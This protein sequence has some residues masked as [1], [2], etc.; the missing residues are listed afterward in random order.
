MVGDGANH[1]RRGK[2]TPRTKRAF[3]GSGF[4][5]GLRHHRYERSCAFCLSGMESLTLPLNYLDGGGGDGAGGSKADGKKMC[6]A[7]MKHVVCVCC[8]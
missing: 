6:N 3:V 2:T 4:A 8:W 5:G 7:Q 1:Q